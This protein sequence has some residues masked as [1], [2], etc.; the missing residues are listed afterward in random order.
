[1]K[2]NINPDAAG[3]ID[4]AVSKLFL[5]LAGALQ[6]AGF[7]DTGFFT[8]DQAEV[9]KAQKAFQALNV[10]VNSLARETVTGRLFKEDAKNLRNFTKVLEGGIFQN[11]VTLY[12]GMIGLRDFVASKYKLAVGIM[13]NPTDFSQKQIEEARK[14]SKEILQVISELQTGILLFEKRMPGLNPEFGTTQASDAQ[15]KFGSGELIGI[16]KTRE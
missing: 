10:Q 11:D 1:M 9:K 6:S 7:K 15:N 4:I 13:N 2:E 14:E 16:G 5:P 8:Q 3:G 12:D